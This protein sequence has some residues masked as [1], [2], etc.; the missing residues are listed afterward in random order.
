MKKNQNIEADR[1]NR[2]S[3]VML[4]F[5]VLAALSIGPVMLLWG[6]YG[7]IISF[8]LWGISMI[9][10]LK[11]EKIKKERDVQTYSEIVAFIEGEDLE[12]ARTKRNKTRDRWNKAK[13]IIVFSLAAG[14]VAAL[15]SFLWIWLS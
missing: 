3:W 14:G 11:I 5:M 13:I 15:S 1:M 12:A 2:L 10:A 6:W 4:V 8:V 7:S 9:A